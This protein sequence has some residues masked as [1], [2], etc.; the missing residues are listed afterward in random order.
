MSP[1]APRHEYRAWAQAFPGLPQPEGEAWSEETYLVALG[2]QSLN[3]K[4]RGGA[5]EIKQLRHDPGG[6]QLWAL[7]ARLEFPVPALA[8]ERELISLLQI[9]QPLRRERYDV[10]A[11]LEDIVGARRNVVAVRLRKR[12]RLYEVEGCRSETTEVELPDGTRVTTAAAEGED[13]R[14]VLAAAG[15]MGLDGLPN[16]SYPQYLEPLVRRGLGGG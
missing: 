16:T 1:D 9:G 15:A 14:R 4:I 12:R 5:L 10:A 11:I 3:I 7:S 13:G 8:L 2:L 6:P